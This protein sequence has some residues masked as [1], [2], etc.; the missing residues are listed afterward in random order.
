M[1]TEPPAGISGVERLDAEQRTGDVD[2]LHPGQVG[3]VEVGQ[4]GPPGDA[5]VGDQAVDPPYVAQVGGQGGPV[6]ARR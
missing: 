5:G 4:P 1:T 2:V 3:R 6:V